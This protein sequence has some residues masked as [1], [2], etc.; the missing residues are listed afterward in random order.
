[1]VS[2]GILPAVREVIERF[3][4]DGG[5]EPLRP[6]DYVFFPE[7]VGSVGEVHHKEE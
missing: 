6:D 7:E 4:R 3:A 2:R 1:M 5:R